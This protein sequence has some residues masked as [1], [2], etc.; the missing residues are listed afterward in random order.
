MRVCVVTFVECWQNE[1][2]NWMGPGGFPPQMSA[3]GSLFDEMTILVVGGEPKPGGISLP[4]NAH[5][6]PLRRPAGEDFRRK[7]SVVLQLPYYMSHIIRHVRS[8]RREHCGAR[9][10]AAPR[11]ANGYRHAK[12]PLCAIR[13]LLEND[14]TDNRYE[15]RYEVLYAVVRWRTERDG[16]HRSRREATRSETAMAICD[17]SNGCR[18]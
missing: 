15:P 17:I 11:P 6:V 10:P 16:C 8:R 18:T 3:I 7:L 1:S 2:G 5:V 12:T 9:R 14:F 4:R 13:R